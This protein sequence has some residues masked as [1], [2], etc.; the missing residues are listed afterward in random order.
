MLAAKGYTQTCGIN[1]IET[2]SPLAKK[3]TI[4]I[5]LS[6]AAYYDGVCSNLMSQMPFCMTILRK[7]F[8]WRPPLK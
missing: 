5:L 8:R 6:L 2:F 1:Y 3:N 7:K 4:R